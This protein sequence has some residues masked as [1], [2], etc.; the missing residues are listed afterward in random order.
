MVYKITKK[1][2]ISY[3][4]FSSWFLELCNKIGY[5]SDKTQIKYKV[6]TVTQMIENT[7]FDIEFHDLSAETCFRL[8]FCN[9]SSFLPYM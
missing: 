8:K 2:T 9:H 3:C 1:Y 7:I 5:N 6:E 4:A